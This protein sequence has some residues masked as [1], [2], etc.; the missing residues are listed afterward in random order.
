MIAPSDPRH[1]RRAGY[2]AGCRKLCCTEPNFRYQKRSK[3]RLAREGSQIVPAAPVIERAAWW[4]ERGV[5]VTGLTGAAGI[6][7]GTLR[8]LASGARDLC[9]KSTLSAVLAVGWDDLSDRTL[10]AADL[11]R[12]RVFSMMAAGHPL[13][14][15]VEQVAPGLPIRGGWRQ[16]DRVFVGTARAIQRVYDDAPLEGPS[17]ITASK[18]RNKGHRHPLA[19]DDPGVPAMPFGWTPERSRSVRAAGRPEVVADRMED[20][21]WLTSHGVPE[22]VAAERVGVHLRSFRDQRRRHEKRAC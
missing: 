9:L 5:S 19:W 17:K 20:F 8:E 22:E 1:G 16:Q 6:G 21:D 18:A 7:D 3:I 10:C 11:T 13:D 12:A 14:W 15:I 2:I 4:A